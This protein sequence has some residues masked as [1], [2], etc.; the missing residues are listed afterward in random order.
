VNIEAKI[1]I[2]GPDKDRAANIVCEAIKAYGKKSI[3]LENYVSNGQDYII[4]NGD[5]Y[6]VAVSG[7]RLL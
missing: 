7:G 2:S 6:L 5:I 1:V 4:G 3:C